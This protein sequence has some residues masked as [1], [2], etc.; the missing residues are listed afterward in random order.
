MVYVA[1]AEAAGID[2][3]TSDELLLLRLGHLGWIKAPDS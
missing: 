1:L 3:I 2:L